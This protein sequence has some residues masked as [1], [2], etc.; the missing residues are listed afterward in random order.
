M[1]DKAMRIMVWPGMA[2]L[3]LATWQLGC[4]GPAGSGKAVDGT[5]LEQPE[6]AEPKPTKLGAGK[7]TRTWTFDDCKVGA[8]PA[9]WTVGATM[10]SGPLATWKVIPDETAP[11]GGQVLAMTSP[12]HKSRGTYNLCWTKTAAF[13]DGEIEVTLKAG[14]GRVDRGGGVIWRAIDKDNYYIARW[15]PLEDNFRI[16][17]VKD[18]RRRQLASAAARLEA[19]KWHTM[20]IVHKGNRIAGYLNGRKLLELTAENFTKPGGVGLWTKADAVT[21]FDDFTVTQK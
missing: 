11:S 16:Y 7:H 15:N 10:Q 12:N 1:L 20:R 3:V 21:S 6:R 18:G 2:V 13:L 8:V 14:T 19:G 4:V 5:I 17:Y 9:G